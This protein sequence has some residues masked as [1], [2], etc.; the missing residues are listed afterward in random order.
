MSKSE[1]RIIKYEKALCAHLF[2]IQWIHEGDLEGKIFYLF[3]DKN[4]KINQT[5][6]SEFNDFIVP[7][8]IT[9]SISSEENY[10]LSHPCHNLDS[11]ALSRDQSGY[12]K[13]HYSFLYNQYSKRTQH[14][15]DYSAV[16]ELFNL[17]EVDLITPEKF[18][19]IC[20][21]KQHLYS[22]ISRQSELV[23]QIN[24]TIS[25]IL[26]VYVYVLSSLA[27]IQEEKRAHLYRK[28][29]RFFFSEILRGSSRDDVYL[30]W[31]LIETD[32]QIL[33]HIAHVSYNGI[34]Y[35]L[36]KRDSLI[37]V[38]LK[39]LEVLEPI[40][41]LVENKI[42]QD[43]LI[44]PKEYRDKTMISPKIVATEMFKNAK[45]PKYSAEIIASAMTV[46]KEYLVQNEL[47]SID[48]KQSLLARLI[49][50]K[51]IDGIDDATD[52][53]TIKNWIVIYAKKAGLSV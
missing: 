13:P 14:S 40:E 35:L 34:S 24:K 11:Y 30:K 42:M 38:S 26:K 7:K 23:A 5:D 44:T 49:R 50:E 47:Y 36:L 51:K 15:K 52:E 1:F 53:K 8:P 10:K 31:L 4:E 12:T 27:P 20:N 19:T 41:V 37:E 43:R 2:P 29:K 25:S 45:N 33:S 28:L 32:H 16:L 46:V 3:D 39:I 18:N 48:R 6:F 17:K 21:Y 9:L 22:Q